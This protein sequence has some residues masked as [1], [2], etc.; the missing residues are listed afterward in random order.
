MV[1]GQMS[2]DYSISHWIEIINAGSWMMTEHTPGTSHYSW[3]VTLSETP[4]KPF[5]Y[6]TVLTQSQT[7]YELWDP[8]HWLEFMCSRRSLGTLLLDFGW[9]EVKVSRLWDQKA[10]A[11][12]EQYNRYNLWIFL[13]L[14]SQLRLARP[15]KLSQWCHVSPHPPHTDLKLSWVRP[16]TLQTYT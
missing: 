3:R 6:S 16:F 11:P 8:T 14:S 10:S 15:W 7:L 13:L 1:F 4:R 5:L 9:R 2:L 12:M